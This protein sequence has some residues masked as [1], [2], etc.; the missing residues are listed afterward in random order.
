MMTSDTERNTDTPDSET[1]RKDSGTPEDQSEDNTT[2][3]S[4]QAAPREK[5]REIGGRKGPDPVRYGDWE[6]QGRCIDF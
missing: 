1:L 4:E 5:P 2:H 6:K 3:N